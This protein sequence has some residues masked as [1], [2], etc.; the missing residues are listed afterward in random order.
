MPA[1]KNDIFTRFMLPFLQWYLTM[2]ALTVV[3][4]YILHRVGWVHLGIYLG[5]IGTALVISSFVYS[6]RK[7]KI[8]HAGSPK[9]LLEW[10]EY[11]AWM[12]AVLILVHAGIHFNALLP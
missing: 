2:I 3:L 12:G 5:Y 7:R 6:L 10:H 9:K 8:M 1:V 4:D 11:G